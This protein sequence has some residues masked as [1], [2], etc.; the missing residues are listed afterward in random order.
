MNYEEAKRK[1]EIY[2]EHICIWDKDYC[3]NCENKVA[4]EALEKQI[5]KKPIVVDD[6][7]RYW[8]CPTCGARVGS[9]MDFKYW[10]CICGQRID[11]G[12]VE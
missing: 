7:W 11:W 6:G 5:P 9:N 10:T 1:I 8:D 12:E 3:N 2:C 4:I